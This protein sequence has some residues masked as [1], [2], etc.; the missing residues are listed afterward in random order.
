MS[1]AEILLEAGKRIAEQRRWTTGAMA[2]DAAG[3]PIMPTARKAVAFDAI[4]SVMKACR[5]NPE[6]EKADFRKWN[7]AAPAMGELHSASNR[8]YRRTLEGV[9]D[10]LGHEAVLCVYRAAI[11]SARVVAVEE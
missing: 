4:G 8:L 7:A 5:L 10:D 3:N 9:N 2:R 1:T 6:D 11:R